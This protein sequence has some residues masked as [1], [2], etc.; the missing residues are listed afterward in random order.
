VGFFVASS[1]SGGV[2]ISHR[3]GPSGFV[4]IAPDGALH[5]PDYPGNNYF[6]TLG[7]LLENPE[8]A[9]LFPD[10]A[11]GC[12]LRLSGRARVDLASRSWTFEPS[13]VQR[14]VGAVF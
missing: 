4:G 3:G 11:K 8:A 9:L 12:V 13:A 2:D 5:I 1:G 10:F 7:N 6:N 14:L